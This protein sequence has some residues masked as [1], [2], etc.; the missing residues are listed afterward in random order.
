MSIVW[1]VVSSVP[2]SNKPVVKDLVASLHSYFTSN[3][4]VA[5]SIIISFKHFGGRPIECMLPSGFNGAWEQYAE[6]Y[7]WSQ[8]TYFVPPQVHVEGISED[9]RRE[10]RISYYQWMPF[11]LLFQAV[12]FRA[13]CLIWKYLAGH[14]GMKMGQILRM[15]TDPAISQPE[16]RKANVEA[17][18]IHLQG[19]L[20][21]HFRLKSKK[22][23]P[24]KILRCLNI[25]YSSY[26]VASVY[27][28]AKLAF[29]LNVCFQIILLSRYLLPEY[30]GDFGLY[31]W[32]KLVFS[33]EGNGSSWHTTG[34]FPR[35][36]LCDFDVREMGNTVRHTV[37]CVLVVNILTEKIFILCWTWYV[38]LTALTAASAGA[39]LYFLLG[40]CSKEHFLLNHLEMS[41][42]PFD[43]NDN[44][45]QES[46]Y[47][48]A[49]K[50]LGTDG[51]FVLRMI[52]A[53]ADVVFTTELVAYLWK[54]HYAIEEQRRAKKRWDRVWPQHE[55]RLE[56]ALI[57]EYEQAAEFVDSGSAPISRRASMA[58][59]KPKGSAAVPPEALKEFALASAPRGSITSLATI[60]KMRRRRS[61][62][63]LDLDVEKA[64]RYDADSSGEDESEGKGGKGSK[65]ASRRNS[66]V[67]RT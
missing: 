44:E 52:A 26:Y 22:L 53:H 63:N 62:E 39:W 38:I 67:K 11:F 54:S 1:Q 18:S 35:A 30:Q 10:S 50:Y 47:T 57:E 9:E 49:H 3:M 29:L 37:Q 13:P 64:K 2:Y 24:H 17:L 55:K 16:V 65:S 12:C 34:I 21:F 20:R 45:N 23:V 15:A 32:K 59:P 43:K 33:S 19:A 27:M 40:D 66:R 48:F 58:I 61:A 28:L 46:V 6:N 31:A 4:L 5:F 56:E 41:E 14:S 36:T 51:L 8:D 60:E 42:T 25:K 7:C